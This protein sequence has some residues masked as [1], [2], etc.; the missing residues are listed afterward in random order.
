M[1]AMEQL[2]IEA[3]FMEDR[4]IYYLFHGKAEVIIVQTSL[5]LQ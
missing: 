3:S 5:F 4:C 2:V 1:R